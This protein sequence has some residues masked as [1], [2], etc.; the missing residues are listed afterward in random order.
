MKNGERH[1]YE[2]SEFATAREQATNTAPCAQ[3]GN[4]PGAT[5]HR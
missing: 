1:E 5:I 3:C 2:P 4:G